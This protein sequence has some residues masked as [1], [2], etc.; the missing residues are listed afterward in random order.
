MPGNTR[1]TPPAT[2]NLIGLLGWLLMDQGKLHDAEPVF[3]GALDGT[4]AKLG[5][6]HPDTPNSINNLCM[7]LG[8]QGKAAGCGAAAP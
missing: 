3:R 5:D 4:P 8:A 1:D 6:T 7:L 2:Q